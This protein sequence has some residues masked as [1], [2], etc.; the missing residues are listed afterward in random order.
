[1]AGHGLSCYECY[2]A[3]TQ[4]KWALAQPISDIKSCSCN[5]CMFVWIGLKE[6]ALEIRRR[7][8]LYLCKQKTQSLA[9]FANNLTAIPRVDNEDHRL[10]SMWDQ[11]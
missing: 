3:G 6:N 5:V 10:Y 4:R 2:K 1:M 9:W 11:T 7:H 8:F